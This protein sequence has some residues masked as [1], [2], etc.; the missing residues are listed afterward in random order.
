VLISADADARH[1]QVLGVLNAV[2]QAG[3]E[4]VSFETK[5]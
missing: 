2:R 3:L 1:K 5:P 4:K